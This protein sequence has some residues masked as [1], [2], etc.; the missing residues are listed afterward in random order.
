MFQAILCDDNEIILEGLSRQINWNDL[1]I[2]LAGTAD[3]GRSAWELIQKI[4]PDILI[5]DIRMPYIDGLELSQKAKELN[6]NLV[7]LIISAYDDFK[8]A[9]T[10]VH[11]GAIDYILKPVNLES[12]TAM[13]EKAVSRCRQLHHD[14]RISAVDILRMILTRKGVSQQILNRLQELDIDAD[15][16]CCILQTEIDPHGLSRNPDQTRYLIERKFT[17]LTG[18]FNKNNCYILES[19]QNSYT[20]CLISGSRESL[21]SDRKILMEEIRRV[22]PSDKTIYDIVIAS[23]DI[24]KGISEIHKSI[25]DC[26]EALKLHFIK[27]PNA[28][29][30]YK[31]VKPYVY[32]EKTKD[33]VVPVPHINLIPYIKER[34]KES[35]ERELMYFKRWLYEKGSDSYLYMTFSIGNFYS[36]LVKDLGE[37]G[38]DLQDIFE[39]PM[40]EFKKITVST[41]LESGIENLKNHLYRVCDSIAINSS[42]YGKLIDQALSYIQTHYTNSSFCIEEVANTVCLSTSYFSTVFKNETGITFTDYLIKIRMEKSK[43]LLENTNLKIYEISAR[44]GYDNSAYFSAAFKKYYGKS[45]SEF[46]HY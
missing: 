40:E 20:L 38:I 44:A 22:F 18:V 8:Y 32:R 7:I 21:V 6:P 43:N 19:S 29:I 36:G 5:T 31:E 41:T 1:G 16:Y 42:R 30:F 14:K 25:H 12:I 4:S 37:C 33:L 28:D 39:N 9:R 27:G 26:T 2:R 23:G 11:L 24:Y 35:I 3:N 45:P 46:Q 17:S 13:L 15:S 10:A 34:D